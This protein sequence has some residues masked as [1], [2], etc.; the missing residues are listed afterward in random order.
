MRVA[1]CF[2]VL[3]FFVYTAA[4]GA[5]PLSSQCTEQEAGRCVKSHALVQNK[6]MLQHSVTKKSNDLNVEHLA[7]AAQNNASAAGK[8]R[9]GGKSPDT[10]ST[11]P[12]KD[13]LRAS[14]LADEQLCWLIVGALVVAGSWSLCRE[15]LD[16]MAETGSKKRDALWDVTKSILMF[17]VINGH[18]VMYEDAEH[19]CMIAPD[20]W[21]YGF[22]MP[23][24][25]IMCGL[26]SKRR[27]EGYWTN[28]LVNNV[29]NALLFTPLYAPQHS[30]CVGTLWF[31]WALA[32]H[33]GLLQPL[34]SA[35][36]DHLGRHAGTCAGFLI[37]MVID[38]ACR[39]VHSSLLEDVLYIGEPEQNRTT[40][41]G[42]F[43]AV[44][45]AIDAAALRELLQ[46]KAVLALGLVHTTLLLWAFANLSH[47]WYGISGFVVDT[48]PNFSGLRDPLHWTAAVAHRALAALLFI[49]LLVPLADAENWC[50]RFIC[51]LF[52]LSGKRTLYAYCLQFVFIERL[53]VR[54][55]QDRM[56]ELMLH[57]LPYP[58]NMCP[59]WIFQLLILFTL[60]SPL[61]EGAF[62]F[63]V[64]PQWVVE[65][66]A[67][68]R[69]NLSS[70]GLSTGK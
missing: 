34:L 21:Y 15:A 43:F 60:T 39:T 70:S 20:G 53:A 37:A 65:G 16:G 38:A 44:G 50:L 42:I 10:S 35:C 12:A 18:V 64:S 7:Q 32:A 51:K 40:F 33:R 24:F 28:I 5:Q 68:I 49:A 46:R 27:G 29:L 57:Y 45:F 19:E 56:D 55:L 26:F 8:K 36:N 58:Y 31:L 23:A 13:A 6:A 48:P 59:H 11:N 17:L 54:P 30:P 52:S 22:Y 3:A 66:V 14:Y 67:S 41:Y 1:S 9:E 2:S 25:F 4:A 61:A 69:R 47:N 62:H 63:F